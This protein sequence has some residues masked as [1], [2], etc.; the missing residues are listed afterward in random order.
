MRPG[1]DQDNPPRFEIGAVRS[2]ASQVRCCQRWGR[3][4][5]IID[6]CIRR[7]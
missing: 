4:A 6:H 7:L 2:T 1:N 3:R 5:V